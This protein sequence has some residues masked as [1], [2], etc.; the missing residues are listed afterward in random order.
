TVVLVLVAAAAA[1]AVWWLY[2]NPQQQSNTDTS[3]LSER[4]DSI[5]VTRKI[6]NIPF[7]QTDLDNVFYT[8]DAAGNIVYYELSNGEYTEIEPT[9]TM[10]LTVPLSGQQ[11]PVKISY[12]ERDGVLTGFG[13]FTS[14]GTD[15]S[16]Y[17]Y[18]FVMFKVCNLPAAYAADG[19]CLLLAHTNQQ[20]AY[21]MDTV[22]EEAY[23][24]N[25]ADGTTARFLSENNRTLGINGA[26]RSDFCM[27][28][29]TA[30]TAQTAVIPFLSARGRDQS[31]D[32]NAALDIYV[33]N[34]DK[35]TLAAQNAIGRY[36]KPLEN[37]AFAFI[38][39]T[40][41]GFE[42]VKSENGTET[43]I[44]SF[45]A[46]Y[47]TACIRSGDWILSKE[48]GRVYSTYDARS[49]TPTGY[50]I[51]PLVFAVSPDEKYIV[52]A[53]TVANAL[54]YQ[55]YVYNTETGKYA[56]FTESNYAA[57]NN[58]RF[59]D[60][61]TVAYYVLNVDGYENV[62]LDVSKIK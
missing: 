4:L 36:V 58:L 8:A 9:G 52:M 41:G 16:V 24:L 7:M 20:N 21:T 40:D 12:M 31:N 30:L 49:Y 11:I 1:V 62:V 19:K 51:N 37:G 46:G 59:I 13:L 23:V 57:H 18:N 17:I 34:G 5:L 35:E 14:E 53:G 54:D 27:I 55:I 42:T 47:G 45:Y 61:T 3:S 25:R 56:T 28:T 10:E 32:T 33:K 22:W 48:D 39:K 38:R 50:K 29:D 43:V 15:A 60:N 26:V 44:S 6:T 2:Q